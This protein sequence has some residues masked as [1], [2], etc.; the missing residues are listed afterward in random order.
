MT[1]ATRIALIVG[2]IVVA[3]AAFVVFKPDDEEPNSNQT[4][5]EA[6][7][8]ADSQSTATEQVPTPTP[9]PTVTTIRVSNGEPMGGVTKIK[10]RKGD[11]VR[12]VVTSDVPEEVHLHGYDISRDVGK[13]KPARFRF[14]AKLEG[15]FEVE[16]EQLGVPI[17]SL[18]VR[19]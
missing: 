7:A 15:V 3:A 12:L 4:P 9:K 10:V 11:T 13:G 5:T 8:P 19:P 1:R 16:L 2:S 14:E 18:E 17:A 6:S